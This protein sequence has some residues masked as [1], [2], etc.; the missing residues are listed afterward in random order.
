MFIAAVLTRPKTWKH[1]KGPLTDEW[2]KTWYLYT[3]E[4]YSVIKKKERM[5]FAAT[6]MQPEI[7]IPSE[8]SQRKKD[9]CQYDITFMWHLKYGTNES[10]KQKETHR[11]TDVWLPRGWM[12]W[13]GT[14]W[15]NYMK[16]G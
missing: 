10:M 3:L 15:E 13:G 12:G 11:Q 8:L 7:I 14:D 1:P 4:D 9:K 5:P 6:W 16:N 2:T